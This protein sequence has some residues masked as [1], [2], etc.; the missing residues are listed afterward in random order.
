M[1]ILLLRHAHAGDRSRWDGNDR[2]RP[3][4][5]R[6]LRQAAAL[7]ELYREHPLERILT[8]PYARCVETVEP[9]ATARGLD[10]EEEDALAE[11]APLDLVEQLIRRLGGG[12]SVLCSHGDVVGMLIEDLHRREVAT[13]LPLRWQKGSTWILEGAPDV[14]RA[15]YLPPPA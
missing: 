6:G 5:D 15:V 14:R 9:L 7:V 1:T 11:G 4:S 10:I 2:E 12:P 8:S 13:P 3:L